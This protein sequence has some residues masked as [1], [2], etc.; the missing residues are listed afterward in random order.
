MR[1]Y[2]PSSV[3]ADLWFRVMLSGIF[4]VA[5]LQHL[6]RPGAVTA[7]LLR[8]PAGAS[9]ASVVATAPLIAAAGVV[10]LSGGIALLLGVR[11]RLAAVVLA[12]TLLPITAVVQVGPETLGPLFKNIAILGGLL[13]F[14]AHR[15]EAS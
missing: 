10:L 4:V 2:W 14:A 5:G 9:L 1:S 15:G 13:H 11:T 12:L 7:H 8:S 6:L 3:R